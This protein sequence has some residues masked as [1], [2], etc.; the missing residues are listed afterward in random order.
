MIRI[1]KNF[2]DD[3]AEM[4][5]K[6]VA[7]RYQLI[8]NGNYPGKDSLDRMFTTPELTSKLE[9]VFPCDKY[10]MTCSRF[11]YS[12]EDDTY[13]SYVH[14]D[15]PG[16][17]RGWHVLIYLTKNS[18]FKDGLTLYEKN[19]T[20]QR[21]WKDEEEEQNWDFPTW[22]PWKEVEY[23][24]NQALI[25]D[26]SYFHAPMN[27]GGFGNSIENSRI[28]HIIEVVDIQRSTDKDGHLVKSVGM[29]EHHHPYSRENHHETL[30]GSDAKTASY[31]R[32]EYLEN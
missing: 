11:R 14:A 28:L 9:R 29:T 23:E 27:R 12:L 7:S 8:S 16:R 22:K 6:A 25:V 15:N 18:P 13:M 19:S 31:E 5:E 10:K 17:H 26:Y 2:Y 21:Y 20:G 32:I 30:L 4:V 1:I 3:P 24:Y